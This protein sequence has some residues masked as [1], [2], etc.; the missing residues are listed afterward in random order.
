MPNWVYN[1]LTIEGNPESVTKLVEQMNTPFTRIHDNWDTST[2]SM[3]KMITLYPSPVF[4]FWNIIKPTDLEAYYNQPNR[5]LP[6]AE[7]LEFE[8]NDWYS[9]NVRNWG[10]KWD[11]AVSNDDKHPD[12]YIE[13]P[14]ANGDNSVVYYNFNTAWGIADTALINLSSQYPDL[15]FTLVYEEE[16]GWGGELEILRGKFISHAQY[17]WKCVGCDSTRD[18]AM[19]CEEC[20]NEIC[21]D[22]G[23]G[24]LDDHVNH[25][26]ESTKIKENA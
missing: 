12:T 9:W 24:Q 16:T 18:E 25:V 22:C 6:I 14:V 7:Q 15:L 19:F 3:V 23:Y 10:V 13:G 1:G 5:T 11:V 26:L 4:S 2:K 17:G 21:L 20:E 8:G